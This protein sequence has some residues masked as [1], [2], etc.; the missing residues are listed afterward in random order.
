MADTWTMLSGYTPSDYVDTMVFEVV[1]ATKKIRPLSGQTLVAGEK[2]SQYVRFELDRFWDGID[3][4][5]KNFSITYSLAGKYYGTSEAVSAEVSTD[6]LRFGWIVPA[7]ACCIA[8]TLMFVLV[9]KSDGYTLKTQIAETPVV[10]SLDEDSVV[11]EPTREAW[12]KEFQARVQADLDASRVASQAALASAQDALTSANDAASNA[13]I[14]ASEANLATVVAKERY[15]SP[16]VAQTAAAMIETN[17]VYVYTGSESGYTA[18]NWYYYN[19]SAWTSG[20]VYNGTGI[21]TDTTLTQSGMAADAKKTGD[22]IGGLKSGLN[23]ISVLPIRFNGFISGKQIQTYQVGRTITFKADSTN[24]RAINTT[25]IYFDRKTFLA[26]P[27]GYEAYI[28]H[29]T[30]QDNL[31]V[32]DSTEAYVTTHWVTAQSHIIMQIRRTDRAALSAEDMAAIN[33]WIDFHAPSFSDEDI[34]RM[35]ATKKSY[36]DG[37][38]T[39]FGNNHNNFTLAHIT[40]IHADVFRYA[41]FRQ[42]VDE[43]TDLIDVAIS[44]GDLVDLQRDVQWDAVNG[45]D[46]DVEILQVV[47]N[48]DAGHQSGDTLL[49]DE[50]LVVKFGITTNTGKMYYYND[51]GDYR[52]IVLNQFEGSTKGTYEYSSA[53]L[54]WLLSVLD[55]SITAN[56][57]V[58]IACHI[59][60]TFPVSNNIGFYQRYNKWLNK[61]PPMQSGIEAVIDAFKRGASVSTT[62]SGISVNH[63]FS[64]SGDFLCWIC[65]H[66]HGDFVGYSETHSDQL[67]LM[68]NCGVCT[69]LPF[70]SSN[71]GETNSDLARISG[72]PTEDCFNIYSFDLANRL[73]KVARIGA[74]VNDMMTERKMAV[75][76]I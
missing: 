38:G 4:S 68:G 2:N 27:S 67:Y 6:R 8:G 29:V 57:H 64:A 35:V 28:C 3:I 74:N 10:K 73:V 13:L 42:F 44:T 37:T 47:G 31:L 26:A 32:T 24:T 69:P 71:M 25:P 43:N 56:K 16:L 72:T 22:E 15:G 11:P 9:I 51:F 7:E 48:H 20:G 34:R 33:A 23:S 1:S 18:G 76:S 12:Y 65:G 55:S 46:G 19:G 58:I 63:T 59:A 45:V 41:N 40:D 39:A 52:I 5:A 61:Y 60:D 49:T 14:A 17:R 62:V 66:Y 70:K 36:Y 30:A 53:E 54:T 50:E 75:Y 21:N